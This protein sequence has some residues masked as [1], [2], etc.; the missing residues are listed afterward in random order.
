MQLAYTLLIMAMSLLT[1]LQNSPNISPELR[2]QAIQIANNAITYGQQVIA[3]ESVSAAPTTTV[4]TNPNPAFGSTGTV[5][6]SVPAPTCVL[7]GSTYKDPIGNT[8]GKVSWASTNATSGYLEN[9]TTNTKIPHNM[10]TDFYDNG[11]PANS[12]MASGYTR[13]L[14]LSPNSATTFVAHI[15][16]DGGQAI[17]STDITI[18]KQD[19]YETCAKNQGAVPQEFVDGRC[20]Y[21]LQ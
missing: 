6:P 13:S 17:C 21:L 4:T 10:Q 5:S 12:S 3:Q 15:S 14:T 8:V 1:S 18:S 20:G 11:Q 7:T 9:V 19:Q 16:G 2:T